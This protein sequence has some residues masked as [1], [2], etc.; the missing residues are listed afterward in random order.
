MGILNRFKEIMESNVNSLLDGMEDSGKMVDQQLRYARESLAQVKAETA[1]IIANETRTK[2]KRDKLA[3]EVDRFQG[4]AEQAIGQDNEDDARKFLEKKGKLMPMLDAAEAAYK[5]AHQ[6]AEQMRA[7]HNK[8]VDDIKAM[9]A[10]KDNVHA[11]VAAAKAQEAINK[12]QQGTTRRG[13]MTTT[14]DAMED[15]AKARLAKAQAM[16]GLSEPAPDEAEELAKKYSAGGSASIDAELAA[17]R[18]KVKGE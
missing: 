9:E 3:A 14:F 6:Q 8:L 2:E 12:L 4:L 11:T 15:K 5:V 18:R 16:A 13:D 17:L 7:M 1:D 10:R